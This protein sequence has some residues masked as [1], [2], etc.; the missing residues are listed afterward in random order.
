MSYNIFILIF[1]NLILFHTVLTLNKCEEIETCGSCIQELHCS[2]CSEPLDRFAHCRSSNSLEAWCK[3]QKI[4]PTSSL[5]VTQNK[6]FSQEKGNVVQLTPQ[7]MFISL[8]KNES[9]KIK[10]EYKQAENYPVDLY[11]IMDLSASMNES[12]MMLGALGQNISDTMKNL[13]NNFRLGFGSFVDK[14]TLPYVR[15]NNHPSRKKIAKPYSF[16]NH[17]SL[18]DD[19]NEFN[20]QVTNAKLSE[21]IDFLEGGFDALMQAI[22]CKKE[23]GWRSQARHLLVYSSDAGFH[24]SGDGKLGGVIEP[25]DGR[26]HLTDNEY[27]DSLLYDYPSVSHVNQVAKQNNINIVF[28]VSGQKINNTYHK[29][30]GNIENSNVGT[31]SNNSDN[32]VELIRE[33]YNRIVDS[34]TMTSNASSDMEVYFENNCAEKDK[35]PNGCNNVHAGT[36]INF[37]ATIR[38][39]ECTQGNNKKIIAIK[40]AGLDEEFIVEVNV[41]CDCGCEEK[42]DDTFE[43]KSD[44]CYQHGNFA[45]GVCECNEGRYGDNCE[46]DGDS[47]TSQDVRECQID[48][49]TTVCSGRGECKCN[50]CVCKGAETGNPAHLIYGKY[51]E[52][53][54]FNCNRGH[55]KLCSGNGKCECGQCKCDDGWTGET[56]ECRSRNTTCIAPGDN[57]LC[58]GHGSCSCGQCI[59]DVDDKRYSGTFCEDCA[60]CPSQRCEELRP[61][62]ECIINIKKDMICSA[63]CNFYQIHSV[64]SFNGTINADSDFKQCQFLDKDGCRIIFRYHYSENGTIIIDALDERICTEVDVIAWV[65]GVVGSILLAGLLTLISWKIFTDVHDRK[66]YA[67]FEKERENVRWNANKNPLYVEATSKYSNPAF[68]QHADKCH[69]H[70]NFAGGVCKCYKSRYGDN[71]KSGSKDVRECQIYAN[72]SVCSGRRE[73]KCNKCVWV[74]K[75]YAMTVGQDKHASADPVIRHALHLV[76]TNFVLDMAV[77]VVAVVNVLAMYH[78]SENGSI[79]IDALNERIF[80]EVDVI[81]VVGSI[82]LAGLLTL[83]SWKIFSDVHNRKEYAR[84]EKERENVRWNAN[85]NPLYVEATSKYNNPVFNQHVFP[86]HK[87]NRINKISSLGG[88]T[89]KWKVLKSVTYSEEGDRCARESRLQLLGA[90]LSVALSP[91]LRCGLTRKYANCC[92]SPSSFPPIGSNSPYS[93]RC[94]NRFYFATLLGEDGEGRVGK[95]YGR[96]SGSARTHLRKVTGHKRCQTCHLMESKP[97]KDINSNLTSK[98]AQGLPSSRSP[99]QNAVEEKYPEIKNILEKCTKKI[100]PEETKNVKVEK[101]E[102]N[103]PKVG[104]TSAPASAKPQPPQENQ[105][106]LETCSK[107]SNSC[108]ENKYKL[109]ITSERLQQLKK[110]VDTAIREHR[111]FSIKGNWSVI[112]RELLKRN[113]VEKNEPATKKTNKP[114]EDITSNLPMKQEWETQAAYVQKCERMIMSR[115][116]QL[117]DVDIHYSTRKDQSDLSHRANAYKLCSRFSRSLFSSKEGLALLLTQAYWYTE[118]GVAVINFPRCYVLGFPDHFNMFVDDF[119]MTACIGMLKWFAEKFNP[120]DKY[121]IQSNDGK[122]QFSALQFAIQRCSEYIDSQ[123][124][125]DIDKELPTIY[126]HEWDAFLRYYYDLL[127]HNGMFVYNK[128]YLL[129]STYATIKSTLRE[130]E[131]Y[132]PEYGIDGMKNIWIIKPGNKCRG[133]GIQLVK[134]LEDVEKLMNLKLKYVVQKYIERP[135]IIH[136]TKFDIRQWFLITSVQPLMVWM[137]RECYLRFSSQIFSL[138]NFHESLHLTNHAVQCKYANV[139]QRSKE[140]PDNNMWDCHTFKAYLKTLGCMEKYDQVI[141]PGMKESIVCAMLA[142]QDTMDRRTNTF[143]IYGADFMISD[144]FRPWL[145]EINCCPD[146]SLCTSVTSRMCPKVMEDTIKVVI[147]RRSDPKANTG[148]FDLVYKQN[149]PRTPPY[150][151]MNLAVRGRKI[152]KLKSK[153]KQEKKEEKK[154]RE[155]ILG[156]KR[157]EII[158]NKFITDGNILKTFPKIVQSPDIYKGPLIQD[159]IEELHKTVIN[160]DSGINF[161]PALPMS[162]TQPAKKKLDS[163]KNDTVPKKSLSKPNSNYSSNRKTNVK[164]NDRRLGRSGNIRINLMGEIQKRKIPLHQLGD[165]WEME[166]ISILKGK[167]IFPNFPVINN[168]KDSNKNYIYEEYKSTDNEEEVITNKTNKEISFRLNV[169]QNSKDKNKTLPSNLKKDVSKDNKKTRHSIANQQYH[170]KQPRTNLCI[171][172]KKSEYIRNRIN[173]FQCK[174]RRKKLVYEDHLSEVTKEIKNVLLNLRSHLLNMDKKQDSFSNV[175]PDSE[176]A[177]KLILYIKLVYRGKNPT[178]CSRRIKET[179]EKCEPQHSEAISDQLNNFGKI[180]DQSVNVLSNAIKTVTDEEYKSTD[181]E[182]EV[183]KSIEDLIRLDNMRDKTNNKLENKTN[184]KENVKPN[185]KDKNKTLPSNP[186]KDVSKDNKVKSEAKNNSGGSKSGSNDKSKGKCE[187]KQT[188]PENIKTLNSK[189]AVSFKTTTDKSI[190]ETKS[191]NVSEKGSTC[192]NVNKEVKKLVYEE[193]LSEVTKEM[194]NVLLNLRSHLL[195]MDKKKQD[196]FS[197]VVPDLEA[198]YKTSLKRKKSNQMQQKEKTKEP[199][200]I[201]KPKTSKDIINAK[202]EKRSKSVSPVKPAVAK[203]ASPTSPKLPLL[204]LQELKQKANEAMRKK[205]TFTVRGRWNVVRKALVSRGWVEK[206]V[207]EPGLNKDL[208][209]MMYYTVPELNILMRVEDLRELCARVILSK[210]LDEHQVDLYWSSQFQ[211]FKAYANSSKLSLINRFRRDVFSYTSKG[212]LCEASKQEYWFRIPGVAGIN[213]PRTYKASS[214]SELQSFVKDYRITAALSLL[215]WVVRTSETQE[216]KV[217]GPTGKIALDFF[218]FAA[219]ECYKFI[220]TKKHEDIDRHITEAKEEEWKRFLEAFYRIMYIG[221]HFRGDNVTTVVDMVRKSSYILKTVEQYCPYLKMDG[222][223]NIWILKPINSSMGKGIHVCRELNYMLNIMKNKPKTGYIVQKYIERPLLIHN[224]KFDIRQW[225]LITCANPLTIWMYKSC[226]LRFCAQTYNLN[227]LH[228]AIHLTNNSVQKKYMRR[229]FDP[230]LPSYLMWDSKQFERYLSNIGF[231]K[232]FQT[233]IHPEM[234]KCFTAAVLMLQDKLDKRPKSFELYGADFM[235]TEDFKAWLIEINSNPALFDSTPVT[236]T[237]CPQVLEDVIKVV[238]DH[239]KDRKASTGDFE[240]VYLQKEKHFQKTHP[241]LKLCGKTVPKKYFARSDSE[242]V[243]KPEVKPQQELKATKESLNS[244][245]NGMKRTLENLQ[246]LIKLEKMR[247]SRRK[248]IGTATDKKKSVSNE[249]NCN[250]YL[251]F[252]EDTAYEDYKEALKI[253]NKSGHLSRQLNESV[254][255]SKLDDDDEI[256]NTLNELLDLIRN[257]KE[258]RIQ[259]MKNAKKMSPDETLE[260]DSEIVKDVIQNLKESGKTDFLSRIKSATSHLD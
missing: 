154:H 151:G 132:W 168:D 254:G 84:F 104:S 182:E 41:I 18:R 78:Y 222:H 179:S 86:A 101:H 61:C 259:N 80:T 248:T 140:L 150:L 48:A 1:L 260:M 94:D 167:N 63:N 9:Y 70:E 244:F 256:K 239:A 137:Y 93:L 100:P 116:M 235:I 255:D 125:N 109:T 136:K 152:F 230:A 164:E 224:T 96:K 107:R 47:F 91:T 16:K 40:P 201:S 118:P 252:Y 5:K 65:S 160:E 110:I 108:L 149:F 169:K 214:P 36:I 184:N 37:S 249:T 2:W 122:C 71:C 174:Q 32:V 57:K 141:Y 240:L 176:A 171:K 193:Q 148:L 51:C 66:E 127:H 62:V 190:K 175:V 119:R 59:C 162:V 12:K 27:A 198:A 245:G 234:M 181:N 218:N 69:Q 223:M 207:N 6:P 213:H 13:T 7:K 237:L 216:Q 183:I 85:K 26:C 243:K 76:I 83:I 90:I 206:I 195:N 241:S 221:N 4:S 232:A 146:M 21:N 81:G 133:R 158:K 77:T 155:S 52:C 43:E 246:R 147:D 203:K 106:N 114:E 34:V 11:Y 200:E 208:R 215:K 79:I 56:C 210:H 205:K 258:R 219:V 242:L 143:E 194:K 130:L 139:E 186:K 46:C 31:L 45:C 253:T 166:T 153:S 144:D 188:K 189:S 251:E 247:K 172:E 134:N 163:V 42:S 226:Y 28:A 54:N 238:V 173:L 157:R 191:Q 165:S 197:N 92:I 123:K 8:R 22:V 111:V 68:N 209:R 49:N 89:R 196:S 180:M 192:S 23:I 199:T 17:L 187:N 135:L 25:N 105:Q 178:R 44:K 30:S 29:L 102:P 95:G 115:M 129:A 19:A 233:I 202:K 138:E 24:I 35:K 38:P 50:K 74:T 211:Y 117:V 250:T 227:N 126:E 121:S 177:Y 128:D 185:S 33:N 229:T 212:G 113:W 53:D 159:L 120:K 98:P 15:Q 161:V 220:K 73:C 236:K 67:R 156:Q 82:L 124:H 217:I 131:K 228:E 14:P 58:S 55:K 170:S 99:F 72:T 204:S 97:K 257:E 103:N 10:F 39:T 60:T 88:G 231:P 87:K 64:A 75:N 112:R 3:K 145:I 142:S 225:F 20:K